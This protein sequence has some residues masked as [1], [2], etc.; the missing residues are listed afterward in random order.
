MNLQLPTF[1][2]RSC[3]SIVTLVL[4]AVAFNLDALLPSSKDG[5]PLDISLKNPTYKN[6]L[7][8]TDEGGIVRGKDLFLQAEHIVYTKKDHEQ[9]LR[10]W[11]KLL[12]QHKG[13]LYR[14]DTVTI[15]FI[16]ES[17]EAKNSITKDGDWYIKS[18]TILMNFEGNGTFNNAIMTSGENEQ[19][20]WTFWAKEVELTRNEQVKARPVVFSFEKL[21]LM[22]LPSLT[23]SLQ[24]NG[25]I[26]LRYRVRYSGQGLLVGVSTLVYQSDFWKQRAIVDYNFKDGLG[27]GLLTE[28]RSESGITRGQFL[29]YF[30][31]NPEGLAQVNGIR[32]RLQ[33]GIISA[34]EGPNIKI[35]AMY[36]KLSDQRMATN[37]P[38]HRAKYAQSGMTQVTLT[39]P[40]SEYIARLNTRIRINDWQTVKQE[41]PL[42]SLNQR[43]FELGD[44]G[45]LVQEKMSTGYLRF[46]FP[47]HDGFSAD[48]TSERTEVTQR[49]I[50]PTFYGP[51]QIT[52][53]AG[54]RAVQYSH[55]PHHGSLIQLIGEGGMTLSTHLIGQ[56][57]HT[58]QTLDPFIDLKMSSSPRR[59]STRNYIFDIQDSFARVCYARPGFQHT[60]FFTPNTSGF[61]QSL[62][63]EFYATFFFNTM[64]LSSEKPR[65]NLKETWNLTE[66]FAI[67][68][69][70]EYDVRRHAATYGS[71]QLKYTFNEFWATSLEAR[72]QDKWHYRKLDRNNYDVE[73]IRSPSKLLSSPLSDPRSSYIFSILWHPSPRFDISFNTIRGYR[74]LFHQK[75]FTE[76]MDITYL[77]GGALRMQLSLWKGTTKEFG[78]N[79]KFDL[80]QQK[81]HSTMPFKKI[82]QGY[83]DVW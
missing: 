17:I 47:K 44:T 8:S 52:P 58:M 46:V 76:E 79:F 21:P 32:Y 48:F 75:Y 66:R 54:W 33:G 82:G 60:T 80:G 77:F 68:A 38:E 2:I 16:K 71:M 37:Y 13:K 31:Q 42:F 10:A 36:D 24:D 55:T 41:L 45:F 7:I 26:H 30:A 1:F 22:W 20:D 67:Q 65:L 49:L 74:K 57:D 29:N 78:F 18:D 40:E 63:S 56:T 72:G 73:A 14:A 27:A 81:G 15:D 61:S 23:K 51:F 4:L 70:G 83:Y 5:I 9:Q 28:I 69:A 59:P 62:F 43:P 19:D 34:L 11:G 50:R 6:G 39:K 3:Y 35:H 53:W 64:H 12:L 25:A